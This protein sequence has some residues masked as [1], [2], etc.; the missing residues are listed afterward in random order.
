VDEIS[1]GL[2]A[3]HED[4]RNA[5][6]IPLLEVGVVR[7]VDFLEVERELGSDPSEHPS[8]ALAQVTVGCVEERDHVP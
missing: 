4:D 7:D 3:V 8:R 5:L 1:E 6:A 2:L